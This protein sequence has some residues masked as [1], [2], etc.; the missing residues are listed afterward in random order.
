MFKF[1]RMWPTGSSPGILY[2]LCKVH[3][4]TQGDCPPFRPILSAIGTASYN[5]AKFLVPIL[6]P[7]TTNQFVSKDSFSFATE[8]RDQNPDLYMASYDV[9]SLFTNIPLDETIEI[10]IKKLYGRKRKFKGFS[11]SEFRQLLQF[12]VK[13]SLILFNGK[14]YIQTDGVAMG[15]PLG[16]HLANVFLSHWEEVWLDKC[17]H[18]FAPIFYRRY[19]DD[20]F[21]LFS[22]KDHVKKFHHYLNSR[23][24][25]MH[26]TY[27][28]EEGNKLPFLDVL[29]SRE[30]DRFSTSIYRKPTFS[31]LYTNFNSFI[32]ENYK[33]GLIYCLL[34]RLFNLTVDW[35]KFH[36][37]VQFLREIFCKN[38]YPSHFVDQCIKVF[39]TKKMKPEIKASVEKQKLIIS[40]PFLGKYSNDL[41]RK[42]S[43][44]A[45]KHLK[46]N[47]KVEV[48]WNSRRRLCNFFSFKDRLPMHLRSNILYRFTCNGCNSIYLGKTKRHFLVRAYEHLG[49]SIRTGNGLTYNPNNTNNTSVL[50]HLHQSHE[51]NGS[52]D[53]FE[54]IGGAKNDFFLR[55]KESLLIKKIKPTLLNQ[56]GSS[57]P[58]YLFD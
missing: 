22:S 56:S 44:L 38:H 9:D 31:G 8:V 21:V 50:E 58:L 15:S 36:D 5:L 2:G 20:T 42:I 55:I 37:E 25:N 47:F 29:I 33:K 6:A 49:L 57:I 54:I 1:K 23:H 34:F 52:L 32:S 16:P 43:A 48:I 30:E 24:R 11:R 26:F 4:V 27:E 17:P 51:C 19:I 13:D 10:C 40:L 46:P 35:K 28:V 39:L 45:S 7:I 3:K 18:Q 14:Y 12:A 53:C 41:K